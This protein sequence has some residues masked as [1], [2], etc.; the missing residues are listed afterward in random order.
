M[1]LYP[2]IAFLVAT[3]IVLWSTPVVKTIGLKS[4][5]VD[6]PNERK[7][8]RQPI[9]RLGGVSIFVSTL[10]ALLTVWFL[11]GFAD[12]SPEIQREILGIALGSS[13]FFL[14]GLA[15]DLFS[16]SPFSRLVMQMVVAIAAW[17]L[18]VSIEFLTIPF[19]GLQTLGWFSL[20]ITV[21][22]LVGMA[23]AI[24]WIDGLDGL[25]AG[26][27]GIAAV[28]MLIVTLFMGQPQHQAHDPRNFW[29][30]LP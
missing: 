2:L 26:V 15:D 21:L 1:L 28:V 20:P 22:W 7:V 29:F 5:H 8:H 25:A 16:L 30:G 12:L 24:N 9:V 18:G 11:G 19:Y 10:A 3:T 6:H 17:H 27:S 14:I 4:G 23:N 13:G